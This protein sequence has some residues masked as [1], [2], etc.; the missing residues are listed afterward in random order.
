MK[1]GQQRRELQLNFGRTQIMGV[2]G[3]IGTTMRDIESERK[4][5]DNT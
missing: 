3:G 5:E 4:G 2:Q 1:A